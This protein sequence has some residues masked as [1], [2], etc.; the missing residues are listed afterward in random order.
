[1]CFT[2]LTTYQNDD[3]QDLQQ[4][5]CSWVNNIRHNKYVTCNKNFKE[6]AVRVSKRE[7]GEDSF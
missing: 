4:A 1:M 7:L 6:N 3:Q 2:L 5:S